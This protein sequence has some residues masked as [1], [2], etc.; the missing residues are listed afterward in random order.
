M[1]YHYLMLLIADSGSTK[2]DW[3]LINGLKS[4]QFQTE[5]LNPHYLNA[6]KLVE[7]LQGLSL[8]HI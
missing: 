1:K 4:S 2:T 3:R 7:V 5:G 8:I 6:N